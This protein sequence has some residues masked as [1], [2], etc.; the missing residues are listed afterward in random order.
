MLTQQNFP[1]FEKNTTMNAFFEGYHTYYVYIITNKNRTVLYT[2]VTNHLHKRLWQ[3]LNKFNSQSFSARY[4]LGHL[5]YYEKFT[6]IQ[7]AI[8]R[9]KEI[10]NMNRMKKLELIRNSN[11]NLDFL[12]Y[13][14][15]YEGG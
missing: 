15:V 3:H 2:G 12:N 4:N 13:L 6:W 11:P 10:K 7:M 5:L 1:N 9:E 8:E 14:F